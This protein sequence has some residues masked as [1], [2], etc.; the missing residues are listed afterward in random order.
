[1]N[2]RTIPSCVLQIRGIRAEMHAYFDVHE[3]R[4]H[5]CRRHEADSEVAAILAAEITTRVPVE[6]QSNAV[7]SRCSLIWSEPH[8]PQPILEAECSLRKS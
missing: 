5:D 1:M 8:L 6:E 2:V 4:I 7:N 3:P